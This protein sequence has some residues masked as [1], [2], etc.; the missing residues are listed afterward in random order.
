MSSRKT[1]PKQVFDLRDPNDARRFM[2]GF[3]LPDGGMLSEIT[4][5]G[6]DDITIETATDEEIVRV[7]AQVYQEL[8]EPDWSNCY[9]EEFLH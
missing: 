6:K 9:F 7:A 5:D 3:R 8:Y 4:L 1:L 2:R